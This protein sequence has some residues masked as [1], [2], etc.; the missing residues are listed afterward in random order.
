MMS[1]VLLLCCLWAASVSCCWAE[2]PGV[3][4][5]ITRRGDQLYDG[6]Q[7]F[8]FISWNIPN[9]MVI[10]DA[11]QFTRPNPWR[12]PDEFEIEDALESVRQMGGQVVRTYVISVHREGSDMG[13]FVHV[14]RPGEFNEEGFRVLDKVLQIAHR[15]GIRVI[16]PFVD[17][18]KWWG[19]IAEYAAFRGK[20]ADAFWTDRQIIDDFKA[21]V[22]YLIMRQNTYTGVA[23]RDDPAVFGWETGNELNSPP[24]WTREIAAYIKQLDPNHLVIDGNSLHGV[25]LESLDDPNIDVITTHHYP[26]GEDQDFVRPIRA[27]HALTKGK[28]AYFVGEFGFV[29]TPH[30]AKAIQAVIDDGISGAL[31][32]SLR[33]HRREGGFYWHMEVGTG[34]NIY[35]AFHWPGFASGDRYDERQI[36]QLMRTKAY[37]I[38]GLAPP[39]L[40]PPR[41]P[42]LLPIEKVSEISW[43]GSAGAAT[44]DILRA[45]SASGPW[46]TIASNVSDADV[47][48]RPLFNDE[49]AIPGHQYWYRVVAKNSTGSS[50]PSN[51]V[52]PVSVRCRTLV[53]EARDFSQ[54]AATLGNVTLATENARSVQEDCHRFAMQAGSAVVYR[55][56]AAISG[57][58]VFAFARQADAQLQVTASTDGK[59]YQPV[60]TRRQQFASEQTVYG[61]LTPV[62]YEGVLET[63]RDFRH[64][65]IEL[66][67]TARSEPRG[68]LS[69]NDAPLEISRV[70]IDYDAVAQTKY[71]GVKRLNQLPTPLNPSIFVDHPRYVDETLAAIDRAA[72]RGDR[73]LNV[74]VTIHVD[75]TPNLRIK[76]FGYV[77][78][79]TQ[80]Y[81]PYDDASRKE[82]EQALRRVF[83]RMVEHDMEIFILPHLDAGGTVQEWRNWF[84]FDPLESYGGYTYADLML[85]T[86]A[87]ALA[88]SAKDQTHLEMALSGEMGTSLFSHPAAYLQIVRQ[89]RQLPKPKNLKLGISLNHSGIAG[90]G[91][92]TGVA[93]IRLSEDTRRHM[94]QLIDACDF[95]GMS[96]YRPVSTSPTPND[97]VRGIDHFMREVESHGLMVPTDKPL[98]FSEVGL[99]G[100]SGGKTSE[101]DQAVQVPWEGTTD[102]RRNPWRHESMRLLRQQ[103][104]QALLQFLS[105]QPARWHVTAAFFW[106]LGSWDPQGMRDLAFADPQIIAAIERHNRGE[107]NPGKLKTLSPAAP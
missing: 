7:L 29:E 93:D 62:L 104:H 20:P 102:P 1:R 57:W 50:R 21:T 53:D 85:N 37:E 28:K 26:W 96:F 55:T 87:S 17:Q 94:Q 36:M 103:Y 51:V 100:G 32:W 90:E 67:Q 35:K 47:Q 9:L 48:Y 41:P 71:S 84:D 43:Q 59:D 73:R 95:I 14:R 78:P 6:D 27:A 63:A 107:A 25:P 76:N 49:R 52:G 38:R 12:W 105:E 77:D 15:K 13:Q 72:E 99:G 60:D 5:F 106:S 30:I 68:D 34:R 56:P 24:A 66:P 91:N 92:P 2:N 75:V 42:N 11:Y 65:K 45:E 101:P 10:E 81:Q 33:M 44:Y 46:H 19:G 22:R 23:Y 82:L 80:R 86:I 3:R 89:L 79:R 64:L 40:D 74:V 70:E 18:A 69:P 97:F 31:L 88:A 4:N 39:P 58:R 61:Y 98:H 16:I 54:T 83:G 8:R